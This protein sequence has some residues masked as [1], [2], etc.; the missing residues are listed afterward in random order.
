MEELDSIQLIENKFLNVTRPVYNQKQFD[1]EFLKKETTKSK[2]KPS[3]KLKKLL[4]WFDLRRLINVFTI[5]NLIAEYNIKRDLLPDILAGITVGI[6]HIPAV[7][8]HL[9]LTFNFN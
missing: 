9:F 7:C 5:F 8:K 1:D 4:K 2:K 6:M 3:L